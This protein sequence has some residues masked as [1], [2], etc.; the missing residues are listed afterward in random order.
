M[1]HVVI[2]ISNAD[3]YIIHMLT[4]LVSLFSNT[5]SLIIVHA[6][7][8]DTLSDKHKECM[9]IVARNYNSKVMFYRIDDTTLA[10]MKA[11]ERLVDKGCMYKLLC[12]KFVDAEE[13]IYVDGDICF[14]I[15]IQEIFNYIHNAGCSTF[16]AVQDRGAY[17]KKEML[18]YIQSI[19]LDIK[20]Y[21]N[22]G[23]FYAHLK[24]LNALLPDFTETTLAILKPP[25]NYPF[26]DQD[27]LN[28]LFAK[29]RTDIPIHLL[30]DSFNYNLY[31]YKRTQLAESKLQNKIIHYAYHKPWEKIFPAAMVYW[32][33]REMMQ[34]IIVKDGY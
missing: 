16:A 1:L 10:Y 30:P 9:C 11:S 8:D 26:A 24:N 19:G 25:A 2:G 13:V 23:F 3:S 32:K 31:A 6:I 14:T 5:S 21:F 20:T 17:V 15:D 18:A 33:Y 7:H 29:Y 34:D 22:G 28:L 12:G 4:M 27:A